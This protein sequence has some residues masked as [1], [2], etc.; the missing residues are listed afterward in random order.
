MINMGSI[1]KSGMMAAALAT[2]AAEPVL[3][4]PRHLRRVSVAQDPVS[5]VVPEPRAMFLDAATTAAAYNETGDTGA[6]LWGLSRSAYMGIVGAG[7]AGSTVLGVTSICLAVKL[8]SQRSHPASSPGD[9][10]SLT[11]LSTENSDEV[12]TD[13]GTESDTMSVGEPDLPVFVDSGSDR[14]TEDSPDANSGPRV[15]DYPTLLEWVEAGGNL[16]DLNMTTSITDPEQAS[17]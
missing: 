9:G 4:E 12:G 8:C 2:G 17:F 13:S 6:L 7:L 1:L 14:S 10:V 16:S 3:S 5:G 15:A 11:Y